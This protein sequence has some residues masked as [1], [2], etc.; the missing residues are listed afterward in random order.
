MNKKFS[1]FVASLLLAGAVGTA[2]AAISDKGAMSSYPV[3]IAKAID[4]KFYQLSD[5]Y[6]V[7]TMEKTAK[8][9]YVLKF[10]PYGQAELAKTLWEIKATDSKDEKGLAFQ[11]YNVSTGLPISIDVSKAN[12]GEN[13]T[14][15]EMAQGVNTWSWMRGVEG[16]ALLTPKAIES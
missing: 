3:A 7:L 16:D 11:F 14:V 13:L 9:T 12:V 10:V 1:T 6:Q 15:V 8:G 2:S 5:G 4:G